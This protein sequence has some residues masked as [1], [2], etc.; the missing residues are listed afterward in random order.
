MNNEN[1]EL[2]M[3]SIAFDHELGADY[4]GTKLYPSLEAL[5]EDHK[6]SAE[7]GV[8]VVKV[9]KIREIKGTL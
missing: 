5:Q 7:C 1:R 2:F 9:V 8:T 3:C 4:E 6:C